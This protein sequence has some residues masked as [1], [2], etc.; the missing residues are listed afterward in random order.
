MSGVHSNFTGYDMQI[1]RLA[2]KKRRISCRDFDW[3]DLLALMRRGGISRVD[4]TKG[5][6]WSHFVLAP[7]GK[8]YL[9]KVNQQ[10]QN[11]YNSR[12]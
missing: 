1:L 4:S 7:R 10:R 3:W 6:G 9:K 8:R 5:A 2:K 11:Q 12:R